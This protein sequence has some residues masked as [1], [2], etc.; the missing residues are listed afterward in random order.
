[1]KSSPN[2]ALALRPNYSYNLYPAQLS[3]KGMAKTELS[4][5]GIALGQAIFYNNRL[6]S[7]G[8]SCASCHRPSTAFA[9]RDN[10]PTNGL[11]P[12]SVQYAAFMDHLN[13]N[14]GAKSIESQSFI[15]LF[16]AHE[17]GA[18]PARL[19]AQLNQVESYK[20]LAT[21]AF[22]TDSL[23][24]PLAMRALGQYIR[25][26]PSFTSKYDSALNH[27]TKLAKAELEGARIFTQHCASC[28]T[29]PLFSDNGFHLK[30]FTSRQPSC[31][32]DPVLGYYLIT[33]LTIDKFKYRTPTLR[34]IE[35]TAPYGAF[36][37]IANL[38]TAIYVSM[39]KCQVKP[40]QAQV[41][42]LHAYLNT[43]SDEEL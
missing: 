7:T 5:P 19:A 13:L 43:L 40:T 42:S 14:G 32:T 36:G 38:D 39:L 33:G 17:I 18:D 16:N 29:P 2:S 10:R 6:G 37:N 27:H 21:K 23:T 15:P 8:N 31:L 3:P 4:E 28:H 9:G 22:G 35:Q 24:V 34:N 1:M 12:P 25:T 11:N 30:K 20:V 26:L 41:A